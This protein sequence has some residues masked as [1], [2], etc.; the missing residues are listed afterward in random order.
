MRILSELILPLIPSTAHPKRLIEDFAA[1]FA[2]SFA[3]PKESLRSRFCLVEGLF[4]ARSFSET[5]QQCLLKQI[6]NR[7]SKVET[8]LALQGKRQ[9]TTSN[10]S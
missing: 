5:L 2:E 1:S 8:G 9:T 3:P 4:D 6:L 7:L 10:Y